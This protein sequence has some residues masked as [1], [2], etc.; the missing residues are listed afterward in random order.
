MTLADDLE[1]ESPPTLGQKRCNFGRALDAFPDDAAALEAKAVAGPGVAIRRLAVA[2]VL[3]KHGH[4]NV[5]ETTMR[6][7]VGRECV[8]Y[9]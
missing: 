3:A 7:H 4:P 1:A 9:R 6:R 5:G 2:R 8:C